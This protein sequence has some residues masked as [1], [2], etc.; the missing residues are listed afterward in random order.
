MVVCIPVTKEG[1]LDPRWGRAD[2]VA[3]VSVSGTSGIESWEEFEVGWGWRHDEGPEGQ[4]HARV[5][6]FLREHGVTTVVAA[7]MGEGMIHML[8]RMGIRVHLGADGLARE[9]A[10]AALGS[11]RPAGEWA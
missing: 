4:H 10:L 7:H 8:G 6:T 3:V 11:R 1:H 5:A 9:A 2:R